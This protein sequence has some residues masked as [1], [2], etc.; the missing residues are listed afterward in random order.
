MAP[1]RFG[2]AELRFVPQT[3]R[4]PQQGRAKVRT[5]GRA[6]YEDAKL[7]FHACSIY[8]IRQ[9]R[10]MTL[11]GILIATSEFEPPPTA[12]RCL[13]EST[14]SDSKL[15]ERDRFIGFRFGPCLR[16]ALVLQFRIMTKV[17]E[18]P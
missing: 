18:H 13:R 11:K 6:D 10:Q 14:P 12:L 16:D 15:L 4:C 7:G 3:M 17:D 1:G 8:Y 2:V 9:T 5:A